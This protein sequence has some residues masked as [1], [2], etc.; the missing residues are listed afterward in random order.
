MCPCIARAQPRLQH[1]AITNVGRLR[2]LPPFM[3]VPELDLSRDMIMDASMAQFH[4]P[5]VLPHS[6]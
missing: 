2:T 6:W 5:F 4:V 1:A 3:C